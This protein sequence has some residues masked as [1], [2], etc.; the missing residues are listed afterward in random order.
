[1]AEQRGGYRRPANPAPVSGPGAL[2]RRT[3]GGPT[4]GA[5]YMRGGSYGEGQELMGL[6]QAAPMAAEPKPQ[7][8]AAPQPQR[9]NL[10]PLVG[11]TE[12]TQRPDEPLSAGMPFGA[13]PGPEVLGLQAPERRLSDIFMQ[14]AAND[15][16]GE[17]NAIAQF[18][19]DRNL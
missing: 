5:R 18:L 19:M 15:K 16:S 10:S 12:P 2:S 8:P 13:G 11:L 6:Q 9:R 17:S 4:Q 7:R 1:M 14:I 3:D